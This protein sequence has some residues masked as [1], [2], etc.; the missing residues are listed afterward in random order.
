MIAV[1]TR[2]SRIERM[3]WAIYPLIIGVGRR[4]G[5]DAMKFDAIKRFGR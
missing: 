2:F 5:A 3:I 1:Q 4:R